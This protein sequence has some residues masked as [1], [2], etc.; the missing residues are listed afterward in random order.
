MVIANHAVNVCT[1]RAERR[2]LLEKYQ[3]SFAPTVG[4][5]EPPERYRA[6][7]ERAQDANPR[8]F[9][10]HR[11]MRVPNLADPKNRPQVI[12]VPMTVNAMNHVTRNSSANT[13]WTKRAS[14]V[15]VKPVSNWQNTEPTY[16]NLSLAR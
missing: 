7:H 4:R 16:P 8:V 11:V 3:M 6:S 14:D 12:N 2:E 10:L 5:A 15:H 1:K 9:A 13:S